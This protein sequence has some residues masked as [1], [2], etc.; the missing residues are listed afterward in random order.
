MVQET[1]LNKKTIGLLHTLGCKNT[2]SNSNV[3]GKMEIDIL[4]SSMLFVI[5][6]K[7]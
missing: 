2:V 5:P 4:L 6:F 3:V 1:N 7:I